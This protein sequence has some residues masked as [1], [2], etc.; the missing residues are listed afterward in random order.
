VSLIQTAIR[1]KRFHES[2]FIE[3]QK[4]IVN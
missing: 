3:V 1:L 4:K 2:F